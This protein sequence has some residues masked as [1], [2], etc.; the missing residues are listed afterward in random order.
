[1]EGIAPTWVT[2]A[3]LKAL[4]WEEEAKDYRVHEYVIE[5]D[6]TERYL[7]KAALHS[8]LTPEDYQRIRAGEEVKKGNKVYRLGM[9]KRAEVLTDDWKI[10]FELIEVLA[11]HY[12]DENVRLVVWFVD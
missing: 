9:L 6:G 11:K 10:L 8:E 3:E 12:G 7:G 1:M 2:W 5:E 4:N